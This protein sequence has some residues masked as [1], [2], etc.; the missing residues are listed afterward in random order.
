M[1]D[2]VFDRSFDTATTM[3]DEE[4]VVSKLGQEPSRSMMNVNAVPFFPNHGPAPIV[5]PAKI[6]QTNQIQE[7]N[8]LVYCRYMANMQQAPIKDPNFCM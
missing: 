6:A 2:S 4:F 5:P 1:E 3:E 8:A 7:L